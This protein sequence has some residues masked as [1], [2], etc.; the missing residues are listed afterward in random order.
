MQTL[1][2]LAVR[3]EL[4]AYFRL[5]LVV[6]FEFFLHA[7]SSF[8]QQVVDDRQDV[9]CYIE[10]FLQLGDTLFWVLCQEVKHLLFAWGERRGGF[11][12]RIGRHDGLA[13]QF[14]A[15]RQG[16]LVDIPHRA[17]IVGRHPFPQP[18]LLR[19]QDGARV[20]HLSHLFYLIT[21]G[22]TV[23]YIG[24]QGCIE[25][26]SPEG[27]NHTTARLHLS[28]EGFRQR[29]GVPV[30]QGQWQKNINVVFHGFKSTVRQPPERDR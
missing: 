21:F 30:G 11:I 3:G 23:V 5:G 15:R 8:G 18:E 9:A 20:E 6:A 25:F 24:H 27:N 17:E 1:F 2:C 14:H 4:H 22:R 26:L 29:V 16:S 12:V 13:F 7:D 28:F 19:K 10:P